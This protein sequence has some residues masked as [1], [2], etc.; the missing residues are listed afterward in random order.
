MKTT[1]KARCR[2]ST[3]ENFENH[4]LELE[5]NWKASLPKYS[6]KELFD[7]FSEAK[8]IIPSKILE[9]EQIIE[10]KEFEISK[11]TKRIK[12][13][14]TDDFSKWFGREIVKMEFASKLRKYDQ[15]LLKFKK[16]ANLLNP[17]NQYIS[18]FQEK[19]DISK[20]YPIHEVASRSIE[21]RQY[22]NKYVGICPFHN[23]KTPSFYLYTESNT[24]H[25]FGC[26]KHGDVINLT[27]E[28]NG[29]DFKNAVELLQK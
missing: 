16:Y 3:I 4:L 28:L 6:D 18:N 26:G 14:R 11:I 19:L 8:E 13:M 17:P 23:E 9:L 15:E 7:I 10:E 20:G 1:I 21:L 27:M 29:V 22:G 24:Y 12:D 5:K 25:C 2:S